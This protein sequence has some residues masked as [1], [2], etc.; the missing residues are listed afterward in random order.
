MTN[1]AGT[2]AKS[3]D[4]AQISLLGTT[5]MLFEAP[6]KFDLQSQ[7]RIWALADAVQDWADIKE[8]VPGMTNLMLTFKEPPQDPKAMETALLKAWDKAN[9]WNIQGKTVE[10]PVVYGGELGPHLHD[11]AKLTDLS[12]DEVVSIHASGDYAVFALGA[13]PGLGYLGITDKRIW[14]PRREVPV[15]SVPAGSVSIG[16]MQTAVSASAGASGWH[17]LGHTDIEFFFPEKTPPTLL[18]AGDSVK[19]RVERII[20]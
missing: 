20:R 17:T 2:F 3:K 14:V 19:F 11:A 8:A 16:G 6:G 1:K 5:A 9:T 10:I 7:R 4:H 15:L 13:H 12:I 18:A